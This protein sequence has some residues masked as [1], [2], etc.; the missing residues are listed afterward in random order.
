MDSVVSSTGWDYSCDFEVDYGSK[1]HAA[2][3]YASLDVDKEL[4]PDKV[5]RLMTLSDGKLKVHFKA[6]EARFLRAS[7]SAFVDLMILATQI[8][9][10]YGQ[11]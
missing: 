1:E 3:V 8:I 2:M 10:E 4:Q 6:V 11:E 5:K 7:F 9:E